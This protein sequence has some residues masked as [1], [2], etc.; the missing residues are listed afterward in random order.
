VSSAYERDK[1]AA[2]LEDD[3]DN[4]RD[5]ARERERGLATASSRPQECSRCRRDMPCSYGLMTCDER[6]SL[7]DAG[8]AD[9]AREVLTV[10][11]EP[12][13]SKERLKEMYAALERAAGPEF[14]AAHT[15][16]LAA[17]MLEAAARGERKS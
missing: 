8:R 5:L 7:Y 1:H 12:G 10:L 3:D 9:L 13:V 4:R 11:W 16:K 2:Q 6:I 14:V 17:K 15:A